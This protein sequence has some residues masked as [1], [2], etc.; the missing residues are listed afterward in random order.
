MTAKRIQRNT[1]WNSVQV[2]STELLKRPV[3]EAVREALREEAS[4]VTTAGDE[5]T[6]RQAERPTETRPTER[7]D[8]DTG[9]RSLT[10]WIG[11][12]LGIGG[13]AYLARRRMGSTS[14]SAWSEPS[15]DAVAADDATEG[16][17]ASEGE[18]Q[19]AEA[20]DDEM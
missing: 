19:T 11:A 17:Y 4:S 1:L 9:G 14:G 7:G 18:M 12:L 16:G 2:L 3:K 8:T 15:P 5:R 13:L 10:T 6:E 20:G